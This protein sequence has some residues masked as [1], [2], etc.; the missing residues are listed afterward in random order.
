NGFGFLKSILKLDYP[1]IKE[2]F[3]CLI[4]KVQDP[5]F[6]AIERIVDWQEKYQKKFCVFVLLGRKGRLGQSTVYHPIDYYQYLKGL[7]DLEIGLH[8]SY[9]TLYQLNVLEKEKAELEKILGKKINIS[10]QHFLRMH[11]PETFRDLI[12]A[13]FCED[14]TLAFAH[15]PGFRSGTAIPHPFFDLQKNEITD[16]TI[17]PTIM[18]DSTFIFHQKLSPQQAE[19][20]IKTLID[21][22]KKSGGDYLSLWHN[23]NLAGKIDENP[24]INVFIRTSEY[25]ISAEKL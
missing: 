12:A 20:K 7:E 25:A 21:E 11:T 9:E 24:W 16:L 15:A 14:F 23:S 3:L 4:K 18:M 2:R 17:R 10:R 8:P 1:K 19:E 5:Y 13:G 22:C 6:Q